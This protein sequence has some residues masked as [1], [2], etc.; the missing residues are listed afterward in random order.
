M[1]ELQVRIRNGT[2]SE[3]SE[4]EIKHER[5]GKRGEENEP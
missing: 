4:Q 1:G 5:N 2:R 3:I